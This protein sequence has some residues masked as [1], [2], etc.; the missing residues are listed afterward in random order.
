MIEKIYFSIFDSVYFVLYISNIL[1]G[2]FNFVVVKVE[3]RVELCNYFL[4]KKG[5][6]MTFLTRTRQLFSATRT[7]FRSQEI[8]FPTGNHLQIFIVCHNFLLRNIFSL[9]TENK[10]F[11]RQKIIFRKKDN[12]MP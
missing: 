7:Q 10:V 1:L 6:K 4:H 12:F 11:L 3:V 9:L 2:R 5:R 8:I